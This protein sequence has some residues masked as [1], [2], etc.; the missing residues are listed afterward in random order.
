MVT[1]NPPEVGHWYSHRDKG[2]LFQVVAF[3]EDDG[4]IELQDFDGDVDEVDLD[5]W[6]EMPLDAAEAPEDG[7]GSVDDAD[8]EEL[9][10]AA[11]DLPARD[12]RAPLD[13]L[14]AAPQDLVGR[15]V[16]DE[17]ADLR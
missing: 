4:L 6:Y 3:D 8:A 17:D 7:S 2:Q 16:E 10:Y 12:W 11:S 1:R 9:G 13:G 5:T 15:D 14:P